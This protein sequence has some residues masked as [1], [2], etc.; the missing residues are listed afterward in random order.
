MPGRPSCPRE[1]RNL[2]LGI[3]GSTGVLAFAL[4]FLLEILNTRVTSPEDI[5]RHL[6]MPVLGVAPQ[7]KSQKNGHA[8][9][10]LSEGAPPEFAELLQALRTNLL[11]A[12]ELSAART[13]LV[14]S[15][16]PG[17]GK[18]LTAA[19]LAVSLARLNQ[20]VLLIDA[21]LRRPRLHELF[22][23]EHAPGLTD[24]LMGKGTARA[25]RK[26]KVSRLWLMPSGSAHR[27]PADLLGSERFSKL[28][29]SLRNKSIGS[30][31]IRRQSLPSPIHASLP[32]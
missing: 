3:A 5:K 13:L 27:N 22:G 10:L 2:T 24:V 17:E 4:V 31:W 25:F 12:P 19:N 16:E 21:D 32:E 1:Q 18:T 7:V 28:I 26:T 30:C 6:R 9:L 15:S 29:D 20:R 8:S 23:E 11:A 14:T